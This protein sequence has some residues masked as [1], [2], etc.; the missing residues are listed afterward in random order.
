MKV[1]KPTTPGR[2]GMTK[3]DFSEITKNFPEKSLTRPLKK[4]GGRAGGKIAVRHQGG[5]HKRQYRLVDFKMNRFDIEAKVIAIEYDPNRTANI[6]LICYKDGVKSYVLAPEGLKVGDKV[7]SSSKENTSLNV[8]NRMPLANLPT[9]SLIYNIELLPGKGGT[10]VRSAGAMATLLAKEGKYAT[11]QLPSGEVRK[12]LVNCMANLG[13]VGNKD[14][15]NEKIG[16]AGRSR[17]KGIRPT[18][19]GSAMNPVD[20]PHGGGE[21]RQ[22]VGL[23]R[24]KTPWGKTARGVKTRR[25]RKSSTKMILKRRKSKK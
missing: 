21:G 17:W 13:Q 16:K 22:S 6:A 8:G 1:Y 5:G 2:R 14:H 23:K 20:H 7:V 15:S 18:V 10:I 9:S 25:K 11:V 12:I 3:P 4:M 19:R 24:S